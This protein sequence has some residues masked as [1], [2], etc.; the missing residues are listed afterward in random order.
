MRMKENKFVKE[1]NEGRT[2]GED[3]RGGS[4]VKWIRRACK[5]WGEEVE[6]A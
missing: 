5:Y 4:Q 2:E 1:V 3:A 6:I